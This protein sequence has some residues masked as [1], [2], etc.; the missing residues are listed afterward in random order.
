MCLAVLKPAK[1]VLPMDHFRNGWKANPDGGGY[2]FID[3]DGNPVMRKGFMKLKAMEEAYEKDAEE[4]NDSPFVVHFRIRTMGDKDEAN[5]HPFPIENGMLIHNGSIT[6]TAA[7]Y[8][9]G[10]SDTAL[11]AEAF[12]KDLTYD[13][14]YKHKT[15]LNTS[16]DWNK[17][18]LLYKD[19]R[20]LIIN[21]ASGHWDRDIWYSN[22]TYTAMPRGMNHY[23]MYD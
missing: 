12:A 11:F 23:D 18:V 9:N 20:Y 19:K 6:G 5:T 21:E 2:G 10:K 15:E 13:F 16:L 3:K 7:T 17:I 1:L 8:G 14:V 22:K 4:N